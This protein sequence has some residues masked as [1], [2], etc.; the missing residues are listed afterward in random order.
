MLWTAL[1]W[2]ISSIHAFNVQN[3]KSWNNCKPK[4]YD[5]WPNHRLNKEINMLLKIINIINDY[6][7]PNS[8]ASFD[9]SN[10]VLLEWL[11]WMEKRS[12]I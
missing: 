10:V 12:V 11:W 4:S 8:L 3:E 2:N 6:D 9:I 5:N 1:A 7:T